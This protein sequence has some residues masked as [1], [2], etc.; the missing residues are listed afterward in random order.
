MENFAKF[1]IVF[2][3]C[4]RHRFAADIEPPVIDV[5]GKVL[6]KFNIIPQCSIYIDAGGTVTDNVDDSDELQN[7]V[8]TGGDFPIDSSVPGVYTI[9]FDVS[10]SSGNAALTKSRVVQVTDFISLCTP[11]PAPAPSPVS[12]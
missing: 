5:L 8:V 3:R 10:D 1:I 7:A 4:F 11:V 6:K 9:T 12:F 2:W